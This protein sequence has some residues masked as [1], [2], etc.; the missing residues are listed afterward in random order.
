MLYSICVHYYP[1]I[2]LVQPTLSVT[3]TVIVGLESVNVP[4][5]YPPEYVY[6]ANPPVGDEIACV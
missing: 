2:V 3:V 1:V 6:D 5:E 4:D